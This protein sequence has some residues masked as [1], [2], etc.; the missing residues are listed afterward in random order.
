MGAST[1]NDHITRDGCLLLTRIA[2]SKLMHKGEDVGAG[3]RSQGKGVRIKEKENG[4][5]EE[6]AR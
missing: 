1:H 5:Y 3:E 4:S 2:E 6:L